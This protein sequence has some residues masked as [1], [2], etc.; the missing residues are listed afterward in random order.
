MYDCLVPCYGAL[1]HLDVYGLWVPDMLT[2]T[3]CALGLC[4]GFSVLVGGVGSS[5]GDD[6]LG[7]SSWCLS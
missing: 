3:D 7:C 1:L 6:G 5:G 2:A 4:L